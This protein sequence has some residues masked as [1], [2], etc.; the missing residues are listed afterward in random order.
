MNAILVSTLWIAALGLLC[1][2]VLAVAAKYLGVHEDPLV[3]E[4]AQMLPGANCGSCGFAGCAG[5][6]AA[7]AAGK[8]PVNLCAPGGAALATRLGALLGV[9]VEVAVR[10][11]A[12]V[13]CGGDNAAASKRFAYD[14]IT[15]CAAA[16]AVAGGDKACTAGCL[17]YGTCARICPVSAIEVVDGLAHVHPDLC[18]ACGKCV[19]AC[20][21]KIIK[22]VPEDR[23]IH[24]LCSSRE[25][26]AAVRKVC[27][28]GCIACRICTK[29]S[30]GAI[31]MD[32]H[33]AVVNY[34]LPLTNEETVAKCPT[35][36][37][38]KA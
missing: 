10:R 22:L 18:I 35:K 9:T 12:L 7:M 25:P 2:L 4:L 20:P 36:C 28:V 5:Y 11:V 31:A 38:R 32:G 3:E 21:R 17:G 34:D 14:G 26:G 33:L 15:D 27:K 1:G 23:H 37:I 19:A 29:L 16:A 8:A 13:L 6:A 24:V 30:G